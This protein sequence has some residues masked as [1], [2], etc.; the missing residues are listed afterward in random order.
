MPITEGQELL[1][2]CY[3]QPPFWKVEGKVPHCYH[4]CQIDSQ[5]SVQDRLGLTLRYSN[6]SVEVAPNSRL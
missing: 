6:A 4:F 1:V 2:N 5:F 3:N